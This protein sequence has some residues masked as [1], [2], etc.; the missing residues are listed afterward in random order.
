M[1]EPPAA[2]AHR[3]CIVAVPGAVAGFVDGYSRRTRARCAVIV[4]GRRASVSLRHTG[5]HWRERPALPLLRRCRSPRPSTRCC[6]DAIADSDGHRFGPMR[7]LPMRGVGAIADGV[8][9][10]SVLLRR[11]LPCSAYVAMSWGRCR[12]RI[13]IHCPSSPNIGRLRRL[14]IFRVGPAVFRPIILT[15]AASGLRPLRRCCHGTSRK[16]VPGG[17]DNR[18]R[19][20]HH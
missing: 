7:V 3:I 12:L 14:H 8:R 18:P 4:L 9:R 11:P 17:L 16:H 2:L 1:P 15:P 19:S 13:P 5:A 6:T 10:P 20:R